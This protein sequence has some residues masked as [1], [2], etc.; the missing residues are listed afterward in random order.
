MLFT[1]IHIIHLLT[2]IIWIGGLSF[3]TIIVIPMLIRWDDPLQKAITFQSIEHRFAPIARVYNIITGV[4]GF[5]MVYLTG[6]HKLYFT[7]RGLP[8]LIMTIIWLIWFVMLFG[9]EPLIVKKMLDR[10][11]KSGVKMEIEAVFTRMNTMHWVLLT[12]SLAASVAGIVFA[13]SYL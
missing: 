4:T 13:H 12:I 6:W 1:L 3:I 8:L 5:V 11:V 2:V 7:A 10:M 9:L